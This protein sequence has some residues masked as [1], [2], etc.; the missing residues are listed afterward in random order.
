MDSQF[1]RVNGMQHI[2]V[3]VQNMDVTLPLYRKLFGLDIPFFDSVQP[4]PLMDIYTRNQTIT[5]RASMVLNL[6]GGCAMEVIQPTSFTPVKN[7][8]LFQWGDI[9]INAV[10][11][12]SRDV[13]R[14]HQIVKHLVKDCYALSERPDGRPVFSIQ[15]PDGLIFQYTSDENWYT[16]YTHHSGGVLGCVIGV[17]DIDVSLKLYADILGFDQRVF[18]VTGSFEDWKDL[19]GGNQKFRRVLL[20]PS[21]PTGGGFAKVTGKNYIELIQV[22]DR[23]PIKIFKGR[24]WGDTGFAHLGLDVKGMALLGQNLS[25]KGFPFTCDSLSALSMGKTKVHCV[26]IDDPDG[27]LIEL[28]E[29]FKVPIIEKWGVFLNVEKRNPLKPLPDF[30][31]KALRFSR[32]KD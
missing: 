19:P 29:V 13:H 20:T 32:I 25:R 24:I 16:Q 21:K 26:Y 30:M 15:D 3:A 10:V 2:G 14:S 11:M 28:I 22:L 23:E 18:D 1:E 4:A 27:I 6:Q 31:L 8:N 5:K 7:K 17:T 9:G 12:K